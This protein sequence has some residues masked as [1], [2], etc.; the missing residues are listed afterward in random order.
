MKISICS[1]VLG[2]LAFN[3]S[4]AL[5]AEKQPE[6]TRVVCALVEAPLTVFGDLE[7]GELRLVDN[8]S[9]QEMDKYSGLKVKRTGNTFEFLNNGNPDLPDVL[10]TVTFDGSGFGPG[11]SFDDLASAISEYKCVLVK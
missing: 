11:K 5:A 3:F 2:V 4:V 1:L 8:A 7:S 10:L 6:G 9:L